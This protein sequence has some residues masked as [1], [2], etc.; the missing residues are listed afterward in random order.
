MWQAHVLTLVLSYRA[1]ASYQPSTAALRYVVFPSFLRHAAI[2]IHIRLDI[3]TT[4]TRLECIEEFL[5][6]ER[7]FFDVRVDYTVP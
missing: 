4:N 1:F 2:D 6:D 7:M 3:P 5:G